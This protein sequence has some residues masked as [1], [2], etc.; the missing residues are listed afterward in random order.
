M[1]RGRAARVSPPPERRAIGAR[2]NDEGAQRSLESFPMS[3]GIRTRRIVLSDLPTTGICPAPAGAALV[4]QRRSAAASQTVITACRTSARQSEMSCR[5]RTAASAITGQVAQKYGHHIPRRHGNAKLC[6]GLDASSSKWAV[7]VPS[8]A[9]QTPD[10]GQRIDS[11]ITHL[12]I[13]RTA[14]Q[15]VWQVTAAWQRWRLSRTYQYSW[16]WWRPMVAM[17]PI[18]PTH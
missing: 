9:R 8:G 4:A 5:G 10:S 1:R 16:F 12:A 6:H 11:I 13:A 18:C 2:C 7:C 15:S 14:S 3:A 17:R